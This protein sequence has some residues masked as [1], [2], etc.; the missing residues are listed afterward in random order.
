MTPHTSTP[1]A[2]ESVPPAV[3]RILRRP[4]NFLPTELRLV[5][6]FTG[7][8]A[9][10]YID[11]KTDKWVFYRFL[12]EWSEVSVIKEIASMS[13]SGSFGHS[14]EPT[15]AGFYLV[16]WVDAEGHVVATEETRTLSARELVAAA[17]QTVIAAAHIRARPDYVQPSPGDELASH[18]SR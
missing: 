18:A 11:P 3:R 12:A 1:V 8:Y 15:V 10:L 4:H 13:T 2:D 5:Q 9:Y 16:V 6:G 17:A 14:D 7:A